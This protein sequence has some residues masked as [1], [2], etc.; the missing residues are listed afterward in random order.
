MFSIRVGC[1]Q[2]G[3]PPPL[4]AGGPRQ[5]R[6]RAAAAASSQPLCT[7]AVRPAHRPG[8]ASEKRL[9]IRVLTESGSLSLSTFCFLINRLDFLSMF[10]LMEDVS[11]KYRAPLRPL[12]LPSSPITDILVVEIRDP[13]SPRHRHPESTADLRVHPAVAH[14]ESGRVRPCVHHHSP[15]RA[16]SPPKTPG[17]SARSP[18]AAPHLWQPRILLPSPQFPLP[19]NVLRLESHSTRGPSIGLCHLVKHS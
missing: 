1:P 9:C 3:K 11:G 4:R 18:L 7:P 16:V 17:C 15:Y 8:G 10:R 14:S 19:P 6:L 5:I 2:P 13:T 12:R